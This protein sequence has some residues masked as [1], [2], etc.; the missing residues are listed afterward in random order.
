MTV[1]LHVISYS[2]VGWV[3]IKAVTSTWLEVISLL[4]DSVSVSAFMG[5]LITVLHGASA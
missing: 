5:L 3:D 4:A 1:V 2:I